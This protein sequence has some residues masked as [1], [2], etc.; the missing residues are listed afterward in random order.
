[1]PLMLALGACSAD[2]EGFDVDLLAGG[3]TDAEGSGSDAQLPSS[4]P[5]LTSDG[6]GTLWGAS[7]T[8]ELITVDADG[9]PAVGAELGFVSDV[10]VDADGRLLLL[11][12]VD[13]D[14]TDAET[15]ET[16]VPAEGTDATSVTVFGGEAQIATGPPIPP[17]RH[18][19]P[20]TPRPTGKPPP[21]A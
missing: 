4:I 8:D 6:R 3:G 9:H 14:R 13:P 16:Y 21:S 2:T 19:S 18:I 15:E 11:E 20:S 10:A 12:Q 1:M 17:A 7:S 5:Y